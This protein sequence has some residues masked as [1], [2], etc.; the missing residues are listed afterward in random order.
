NV[1]G[2]RQAA[3]RGDLAFGTADS[4]LVAR[5]TAGRV[6]ATDHTNASRTMLLDIHSLD[7]DPRLLERLG[8]PR[9]LLPQLRP[10]SGRFGLTDPEV[11]FGAAVPVSGI[12]GD[13][14]AAL[15]GQ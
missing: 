9:A 3:G 10:S 12:A 13:Q 6:H 1:E 2:A 4:Y 8:V 11:F 14:Q 15:F 5:L 7:W